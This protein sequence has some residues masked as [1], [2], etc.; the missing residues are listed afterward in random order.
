MPRFFFHIRGESGLR[1]D[2]E[3]MELPDVEAARKEAVA[4]ACEVWSKRPPDSAHNDDTFEISNEAGEV[5]RLVP[6]SEAFA[7]RAVT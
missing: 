2:P 1:E 5:V 4:R 3:G 6:F 7:E